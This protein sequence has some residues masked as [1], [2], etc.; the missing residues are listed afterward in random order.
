MGHFTVNRFFGTWKTPLGWLHAR[1]WAGSRSRLT[2][3]ARSHRREGPCGRAR[4]VFQLS[5]DRE[6]AERNVVSAVTGAL[7]THSGSWP[8][9][10]RH[11]SVDHSRTTPR[12]PTRRRVFDPF[13]PWNARSRY[14][15]SLSMS[16]EACD[17]VNRHVPRAAG[18]E[19]A[20]SFGREANSRGITIYP[21]RSTSRRG[22]GARGA[23]VGGRGERGESSL[24]KLS[25][26]RHTG[27]RQWMV[28]GKQRFRPARAR[29]HRWKLPKSG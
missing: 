23:A 28:L 16:L 7:F 20:L 15:A 22:R 19:R 13:S 17:D 14:L 25:Y 18:A 27:R 26:L 8:S 5:R 6:P 9:G 1:G 3:S 2:R 21:P 12:D 10:E 24:R 11:I 29:I 4:V